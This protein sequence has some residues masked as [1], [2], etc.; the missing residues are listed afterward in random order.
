MKPWIVI[1]HGKLLARMSRRVV[2]VGRRAVI[3]W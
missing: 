3:S 2:A 1:A